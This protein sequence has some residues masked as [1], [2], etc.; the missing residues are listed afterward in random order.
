MKLATLLIFPALIA[1]T[2]SLF[3]SDNVIGVNQATESQRQVAIQNLR[4][5]GYNPQT[6]AS[7]S[8]SSQ[9]NIV[10][11]LNS[12]LSTINGA[13]SGGSNLSGQAGAISN[14]LGNSG[15]SLEKLTGADELKGFS[16]T[17]GKLG[18][19]MQDMFGMGGVGAASSAGGGASG[20]AAGG[21]GALVMDIGAIL[22][23]VLQLFQ[24]QQQSDLLGNQLETLAGI[25]NINAEQLA[26]Q[27][28]VY[29]NIGEVPAFYRKNG[30]NIEQLQQMGQ[31]FG[32]AGGSAGGGSGSGGTLGQLGGMSGALSAVGKLTK[33]KTDSLFN[34]ADGLSSMWETAKGFADDPL[35]T[36]MDLLS[37]LFGGKPQ[38]RLANMTYEEMVAAGTSVPGALA[39]GMNLGIM[40]QAEAAMADAQMAQ[41]R[42]AKLAAMARGARTLNEQ[43]AAQSEIQLEQNRQLVDSNAKLEQTAQASAANAEYAAEIQRR[44]QLQNNAG[45]ILQ[46]GGSW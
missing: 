11:T 29:G 35:G 25:K 17:L 6:P 31:S 7:S 43:T 32:S 39:S 38:N 8:G 2:P 16:S 42:Q 37:Q 34:V 12:G 26:Y 18:D 30:A 27:Q 13:T 28:G 4:N 36:S 24:M 21:G 41:Q 19:S 9:N 22:Q 5:M 15:N 10:N 33:Q 14:L 45:V 40:E 46:N 3:S 1:L 23:S 20:G 44:Q